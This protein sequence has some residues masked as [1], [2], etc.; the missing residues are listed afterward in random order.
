MILNNF[1]NLDENQKESLEKFWM[2]LI[3]RLNNEN[4][5]NIENFDNS[6][7]GKELFN[8]FASDNPAEVGS[9]WKINITNFF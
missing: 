7:Y 1:D 9:V 8:T 5:F 3:E 2:L 4:N 6:R